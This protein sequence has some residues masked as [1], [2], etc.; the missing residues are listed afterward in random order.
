MCIG[1][2]FILG[3]LQAAP[4]R[5]GRVVVLQSIGLD[6]NREAFEEMFDGWAAEHAPNH[7]EAGPA[8]WAAYRK[9]LYGGDDALLSVPESVLPTLTAPMLVLQGNDLHH[10][11]S[12]SRLLAASVPGAT[13]IENWKSPADLPA[14][15]AAI[16]EFLGAGS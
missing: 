14:A 7:P 10:P 2:P 4:E 15:R 16:A 3:L 5:V 6:D 1:G 11:R 8:E 9:A 13:L 12:A